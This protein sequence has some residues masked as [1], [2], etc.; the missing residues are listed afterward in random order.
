MSE[1]T[2][3]RKTPTVSA[4]SIL[5]ALA[6][7]L[8]Q[9]K[10]EDRLTFADVGRVLG[11]SEDQAAKYCEGTAEMG[12]TAYYFAKQAWNGRFTGR[13]DNLILGRAN[14]TTCD[15]SKQS[16]LLKAALDLS[17]ALEDGQLS[18]EE[19]RGNR[20]SLEA[21]RDAIGALLSRIG[22]KDVRA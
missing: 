20:K 12:V 10:S 9:I 11:R 2:I 17:L 3:V 18:D 7:D 22:P 8:M 14:D 15:Q 6:R 4:S 21:A 1:P 13:A 5:D 16:R 19:I